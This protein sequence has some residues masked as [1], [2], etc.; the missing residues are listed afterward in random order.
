MVCVNPELSLFVDG[1][2]WL[3]KLYFK[4]RSLAKEPAKSRAAL[5]LHLLALGFGHEASSIGILDVRR[6]T[7][8]SQTKPKKH[9]DLLL[10]GEAA[11]YVEIWRG[12]RASQAA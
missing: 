10:Q 1:Q 12:L 6:G 8:V 3:I 2:G 11:A 5:I 7:L 9:A 4:E